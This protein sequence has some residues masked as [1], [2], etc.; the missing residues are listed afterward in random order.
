MLATNSPNKLFDTFAA[1]RPA[2]V[3]TDGWQRELVERGAGLF[4]RPGDPADLADQV[5]RLRDDPALAKRLGRGARR[6]AEEEFDRTLLAE[7]LREVLES[8]LCRWSSRY[9]V[10]NTNGRDYL[11]ACLDAIER[12]HPAGV[13]HEI[14]VLDNC[15]DDGSAA[16]VEASDARRA[17]DRARPARAARPRTTPR[18]CARPRAATASC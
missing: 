6:L 8:R 5:L 15:S 4:A 12:T 2:I 10:V 11:L 1:G 18:S 17:G 7:R 3:N 9:C 16:A 13:E 14:L